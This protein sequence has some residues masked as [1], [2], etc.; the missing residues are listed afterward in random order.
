MSSSLIDLISNKSLYDY[1]DFGAVE[2][3][4]LSADLWRDLKFE[5]FC[6]KCKANRVF[7]CNRAITDKTI[8]RQRMGGLIISETPR[9]NEFD[10]FDYLYLRF[11]CS[12]DSFHTQEYFF[13]LTEESHLI[14]VGQFPSFADSELLQAS[15][16]QKILGKE[17][18]KELKRAIGL[19]S[20]GVGIGSFVYLRRII[21]KLVYDA[22]EVA[23]AAGELTEQQFEFKENGKYRNGMEDK[24]KL[25]KGYLPDLITKQPK[26]YGVV[27]K[28]IHE[29]TEKECLRLFPIIKGG[30]VLILNEI[31]AEKEKEKATVEY[32]K[33]L[34]YITSVM[35]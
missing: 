4:E 24:I 27:S 14:K 6:S 11:K 30:I 26:V 8:V 32:T 7:I 35:K 17:Y 28:G 33:S 19:Y 12:M 22:F 20:H 3:R 1:V 5:Q 15:K 21:E 9:E 16:Y 2:I 34:S 13:V 10:G 25:L 29:L 31:V 18:Y 23:K